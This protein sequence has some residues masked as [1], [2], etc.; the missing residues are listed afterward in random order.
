MKKPVV[1]LM[2]LMS[3]MA[4]ANRL[5]PRQSLTSADMHICF[6]IFLYNM[7]IRKTDP[8]VACEKIKCATDQRFS[9]YD[10]EEEAIGLDNYIISGY[11]ED[12][13][14]KIC[15]EDADGIIKSR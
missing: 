14:K 5:S 15:A 1:A 4:S 3:V 10:R 13:Y 8:V 2:S 6:G 11:I 12:I 7:E 9:C